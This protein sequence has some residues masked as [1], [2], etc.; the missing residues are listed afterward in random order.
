MNILK[1]ID[2]TSVKPYVLLR[3]SGPLVDE[4]HKLGIEVY[5][6]SELRTVPYNQST[7]TCYALV[8]AYHIIH[9]F[10][11]F[12]DIVLKLDVDAVYL[13]TMMLYPYLRLVKKIGKKTIIHLREHWPESEHKWQRK[14]AI[15][16][17]KT[18]ADHIV[19]INLYS[20]SML[21]ERTKTAVVVYDW[22]DF[23]NRY[24]PIPLD[25]IFQEDVSNKKVFLFTGG[26]ARIK[27]GYQVLKCF[28]EK[29]KG[30]DKRLLFMGYDMNKPTGGLNGFLKRVLFS[31][32]FDINDQYWIEKDGYY[33]YKSN[34]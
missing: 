7:L 2:R 26:I 9:S 32:G 19:A 11:C 8:N 4:I 30:D 33:Y 25:G 17:I 14:L 13:N 16:H 24:E 6:L 23:S 18:F 10:K 20:A 12:K 28:T 27:G 21:E 22:I 5:F 29:M 31:I 15:E 34:L 1:S 3:N